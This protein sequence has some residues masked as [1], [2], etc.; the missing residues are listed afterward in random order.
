MEC[1]PVLVLGIVYGFVSGFAIAMLWRT[2]DLFF[3]CLSN[4]DRT[5]G[6]N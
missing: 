4:K 6:K 1:E 5:N 3:K 2:I